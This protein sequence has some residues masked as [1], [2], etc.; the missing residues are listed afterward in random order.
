[1][2]NT[3]FRLSLS[4]VLTGYLVSPCLSQSSTVPKRAIPERLTKD[5]AAN[6]SKEL[7]A[8]NIK[9]TGP[10]FE[11]HFKGPF[12]GLANGRVIV[13]AAPTFVFGSMWNVRGY[14]GCIYDI[15]DSAPVFRRLARS[16]EFPDRRTRLP[17][18]PP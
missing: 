7:K 10:F 14:T 17:G 11:A 15:R 18:E 3:F 1:M 13:I 5:C 12:A 16:N 8:I 2:R 4:V 9:I 6:I